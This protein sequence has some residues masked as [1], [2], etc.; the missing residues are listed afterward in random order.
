MQKKEYTITVYTENQVGL[1]NRIAIIFSRSCLLYT[2]L[3][4]SYPKLMRITV[5]GILNK[6]VVSKDIVLYI[7]SKISASGATGFAV[8]FAGSA[9][10]SLSMEARMTIC[11][12]SIE[13]GGR[14]GLIAPDETTDVYK[15]QVFV[16]ILDKEVLFSNDWVIY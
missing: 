2:S 1:L 16:W 6:G 9:I 7:L 14:C 13:M 8:E 4:Q 11:K 15:R 12:M 3:M 10:R 5:D